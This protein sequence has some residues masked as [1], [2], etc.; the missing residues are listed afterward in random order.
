MRGASRVRER[1]CGPS[2]CPC[3]RQS[4]AVIPGGMPALGGR[5]LPAHVALASGNILAIGRPQADSLKDPHYRSRVQ[6]LLVG[7]CLNARH[8]FTGRCAS[9]T[10]LRS[11]IQELEQSSLFRAAAENLDAVDQES[12]VDGLAWSRQRVAILVWRNVRR[13]DPCRR[14]RANHHPVERRSAP[15]SEWRSGRDMRQAPS[16]TCKTAPHRGRPAAMRSGAHS[17][18]DWP[19]SNRTPHFPALRGP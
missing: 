12:C 19:G 8:Q 2:P 13:S 4:R 11:A 10:A 17:C 15:P 6:G 18:A 5:P 9:H 1:R 7:V 3:R 14:L 16:G